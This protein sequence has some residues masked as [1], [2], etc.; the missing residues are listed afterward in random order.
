MQISDKTFYSIVDFAERSVR[1]QTAPSR[2]GV[3]GILTRLI[4]AWGLYIPILE[5]IL[6]APVGT[7]EEEAWVYYHEVGHW[8]LVRKGIFCEDE[9]EEEQ[10]CNDIAFILMNRIADETY[11]LV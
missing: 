6:V 8:A 7:L 3:W 10:I 4:G 1:N 11:K 9:K 2:E 5:R